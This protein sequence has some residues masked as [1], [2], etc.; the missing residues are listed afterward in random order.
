MKERLVKLLMKKLKRQLYSFIVGL[1]I[2]HVYETLFLQNV[3]N[4]MLCISRPSTPNQLSPIISG[5]SRLPGQKTLVAA[6][7]DLMDVLV[8][9]SQWC[10][11]ELLSRLDPRNS[12]NEITCRSE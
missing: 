9:G 12:L 8:V 2:L 5:Q 11:P 6:C 7:A 4:I 1:I 10:R 3:Q